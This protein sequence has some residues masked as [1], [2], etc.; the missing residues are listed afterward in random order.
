M[1][2]HINKYP[3]LK[4]IDPYP[5]DADDDVCALDD[6]PQGWAKAFGEMMCEDLDA[7]LKRAGLENEFTIHQ[8]KEK[9]G[10]MRMYYSPTTPEIDNILFKYESISE[11]ICINCSKP[12]V[13]TL[14]RTGY[15]VPMCK[16]C[17]EQYYNNTKPYKDIISKGCG[18]PDVLKY[19]QYSKDYQPAG[20]ID[21]AID[22][23]ETTD[24][25]RKLWEEKQNRKE[26][27]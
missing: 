10:S 19:R 25:I 23:S 18:M 13:H 26:T 14:I 2:K 4:T 11:H 15:I 7:E 12:D 9:N 24:K 27:E 3:W 22:I 21:V 16:D 20:Y 1:N 8:L 6:L 5:E 17:Y